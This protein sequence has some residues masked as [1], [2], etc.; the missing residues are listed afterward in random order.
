MKSL[1][2]MMM[3]AKILTSV[4][5]NSI[6]IRRRWGTKMEATTLASAMII[7]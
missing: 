4:R 2:W 7:T 3:K 5:R 6:K 1:M